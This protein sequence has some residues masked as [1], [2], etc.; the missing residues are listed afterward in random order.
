MKELDKLLIDGY[1]PIEPA[2]HEVSK[3]EA[4][5]ALPVL[6]SRIAT[7]VK[8]EDEL[9]PGQ[10]RADKAEHEETRR[11]ISSDVDVNHVVAKTQ[12]QS[13]HLRTGTRVV[14]VVGIDALV[15]G[16]VHHGACGPTAAE[17]IPQCDEICLNSA[18][19]RRIRTEK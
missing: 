3:A 17:E 18:P 9:C 2:Q 4:A 14:D 15:S 10:H 1:L 8:G 11:K 6:R 16:E 5:T 13:Q 7:R 19:W 12:E